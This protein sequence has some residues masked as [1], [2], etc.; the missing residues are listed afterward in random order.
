[1][2][3]SCYKEHA[4]ITTP[5]VHFSLVVGLL[6]SRFRSLLGRGYGSFHFRAAQNDLLLGLSRLFP[7]NSVIDGAQP[8]E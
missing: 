4:L 8:A 1:M 5:H 3:W 7:R 2:K 6:N